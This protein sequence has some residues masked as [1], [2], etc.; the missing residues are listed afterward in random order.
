MATAKRGKSSSKTK[1]KAR[2]KLEPARKPVKVTA[3]DA[4]KGKPKAKTIASGKSK[5]AAKSKAT[6]QARSM[7]GGAPRKLGARPAARLTVSPRPHAPEPRLP[8]HDQ[9]PVREGAPQ[10]AAWGVFGD[11]DQLGTINLLTPATVVEAAASIRSGETFALNLS[12]DIPDPPLFGR[13]KHRHVIKQYASYIL[14]DYL[15]NFYPQ[16]S[17]Q[18]DALCHVKHPK[19]GGYNG[20]G[21]SEITGYGGTKLG[22]DNLARRGIAGRGVLADIGRYHERRGRTLDFMTNEMI[23]LEDLWEA[24]RE[25]KTE[26]R[27]GD[28]LLVRIGWTKAYLAMTPEQKEAL[29]A[30]TK[31]PG[32]EGTARTAKWLWDSR[33]SAVA[34]DSPALEAMPPPKTADFMQSNDLLHFHM[35]SFFGMPIGEMWNLEELAEACAGDGH[36]DFFFTSAPL[37]IPGGVGS[38]PNAIAV[39]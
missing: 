28:V 30:R 8:H 37:N 14:D 19:H 9:L 17:S 18:W 31:S 13:G 26:L 10:G 34:S 38:P 12:I 7:G 23:A 2:A 33:I 25:Q 21:D 4:S 20:F 36:Y 24:L 22:I 3:K 39:K 27:A 32:I 16:A 11:N 6:L 35:L 1:L 29:A 5:P 15:D